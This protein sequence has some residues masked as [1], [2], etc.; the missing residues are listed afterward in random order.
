MLDSRPIPDLY[1]QNLTLC[2][3]NWAQCHAMMVAIKECQFSVIRCTFHKTRS[4]ARHEQLDPHLS[5]T[6][7]LLIVL[8]KHQSIT[9][10]GCVC[11]LLQPRKFDPPDCT[12][13][14][15]HRPVVQL[16]VLPL[17]RVDWGGSAL[18]VVIHYS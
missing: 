9:F 8:S 10:I 4:A 14:S 7:R 1:C 15:V 2:N 11:R 3:Y 18:V 16:H 5:C 6:K 12:R 13:N 17:A